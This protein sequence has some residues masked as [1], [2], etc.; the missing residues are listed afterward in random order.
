MK[1]G[2]KRKREGTTMDKLKGDW[3]VIG[4]QDKI[5]DP[6][7]GHPAMKGRR[8]QIDYAYPSNGYDK[9]QQAAKE[10]EKYKQKGNNRP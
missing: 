5:Q 3:Y 6:L 1:N 9:M 2:K 8:W 4:A 7:I 10:S